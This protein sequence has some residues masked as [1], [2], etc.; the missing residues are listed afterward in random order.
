MNRFDEALDHFN[1]AL[2]ID[3]SLASVHNS[4][5]LVHQA[6]NRHDEAKA[7]FERAIELQPGYAEAL[8]NLAI[9]LHGIGR[10]GDAIRCYQDALAADGEVAEIYFNLGSLLQGL[11][12][13]D[14]SVGV[15]MKALQVR[16]DYNA[17]YSFLAHSLLQQCSWQNLDAVIA[18]TIAQTKHEIASDQAVSAS[19]FALQSMPVPPELRLVVARHVAKRYADGVVA[20]G[21]FAHATPAKPETRKL[22]VGYVSPDFRFHSVAVAFKGLLEHHDRDRFELVGYSLATAGGGPT[23]QDGLTEYFRQNFDSFVD[24]DGV[25]F[26]EAGQRVNDDHIDILVDLA[27][28]TRGTRLELFALRPAPIQAHYLGYSAT[29]GADYIQYLIT[30]RRVPPENERYFHEKLVFLPDTFMATT[31]TTIDEHEPTRAQCGLPETGLVFANFNSHYKFDPWIFAIW[32]RLLRKTPDSV[33]WFVRGTPTSREN[34][35]KEAEKRGVAPERLIFGE[36]VPHGEHLARHR[37]V[38]LALDN[39]IHGGGVTTVDAL[40][41]GVPVLT[42]AG[43]APQSR[44]GATLL[45]A[46]GVAELVTSSLDEYERSAL[47]LAVN[48]GRLAELKAKVEANRLTQP[49]FDTGRLTRH[50]EIAYQMMWDNHVAGRPPQTMEVPPLPHEQN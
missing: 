33:M 11:G 5:G 17:V 43:E 47:G 15:Y 16:P 13:Y 10:Y 32:M 48:P 28:H 14:E 45:N 40:W 38:D 2:R 41:M 44:N 22:R 12:R 49:L 39:Q 26:A 36:T 1:E 23:A 18:A 31:Q 34:L 9:S 42:V 35:R 27:G 24:L 20:L 37:L 25:P 30:D 3:P 46:L 50:L 21:Q 7:C 8:N 29:I 19:A 6:F 4:I